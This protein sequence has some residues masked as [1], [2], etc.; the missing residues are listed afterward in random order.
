MNFDL[1]GFLAQL[2]PYDTLMLVWSAWVISWL[3]AAAW[4]AQTVK[5]PSLGSEALYRIVTVAGFVLLIGFHP[6]EGST[7]ILWRTPEAVRW[8][9][10]AA[11]ALC[12]AFAWW[13]RIHLGKL[14]SGRVTRKENHRIVDTGPY[15][16]VRHPIYTA[17]LFA[18]LCL[19]IF[20]GDEIAF[21]GFAIATLGFVI[22]ARL[23]EK[24]LRSELG[25]EAYDA[26][27]RRVPML[28]PGF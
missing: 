16:I 23:E 12:F 13:A 8:L 14:W 15:A 27:A 19:A 5:R 21:A 28:V 1:Q 11:T 7:L 9:L 22:K 17:L 2:G 26:Y 18:A 3:L 25:P 20:R 10:V 6:R 4:S 24:F